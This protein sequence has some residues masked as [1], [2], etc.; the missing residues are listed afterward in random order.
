MYPKNHRTNFPIATPAARAAHS[1]RGSLPSASAEILTV[2]FWDKNIRALKRQYNLTFKVAIRNSSEENLFFCLDYSWV[3]NLVEFV[4]LYYPKNNLTNF[5]IETP[6]ARFAHSTSILL[7]EEKIDEMI[8]DFWLTI[9][10][11]RCLE[12]FK[13]D[14]LSAFQH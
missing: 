5:A 4:N 1:T 11:F 9:F 6:A 8:A 7:T 14:I 13:I 3:N 12:A 2:I 10:D